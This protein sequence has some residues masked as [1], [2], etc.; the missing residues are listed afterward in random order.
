[1]S[2]SPNSRL[3][4]LIAEAKE[5]GIK[6]KFVS[7]KKLLD[8]AAINWMTAKLFGVP[9][10]PD[11]TVWI[12]KKF[13]MKGRTLAYTEFVNLRHELYEAILLQKGMT[14]WV[15]HR[16][17]LLFEGELNTELPDMD[18]DVKCEEIHQRAKKRNEKPRKCHEHR[19]MAISIGGTRHA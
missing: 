11:K 12:D 15:A 13:R 14:Y 10:F 7:S 9:N 3:T 18:M 6:V 16:K 17:S 8:F 5:N 19:S 2:K 4:E 1:M